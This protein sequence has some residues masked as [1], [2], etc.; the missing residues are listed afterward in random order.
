MSWSSLIAGYAQEGQTDEALICFEHMLSEGLT[1][2]DVT[3]ACVLS[4]CNHSGLIDDAQT[5]FSLMTRR[6][7]VIPSLEHHTCM[8]M[9][10]G[11]GGYF[12]EA[13]SMIKAMPCSDYPS[14]WLTLLGAC[15]KWGNMQL[16]KMVFDK[17]I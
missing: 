2:N 5:F 17:A 13:I 6:Y 9:G 1:P 12:E 15:G 14:V 10:F 8:I 4:A 7:G 3:F 11:C 16:G